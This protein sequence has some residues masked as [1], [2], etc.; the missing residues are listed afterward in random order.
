MT[1]GTQATQ[2]LRQSRRVSSQAVAEKHFDDFLPGLSADRREKANQSKDENGVSEELR[3][4][5]TDVFLPS[6]LDVIEILTICVD[7][8][9]ESV[10]RVVRSTV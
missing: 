8:Q 3:L 7:R 10:V 2:S 1:E 5:D 6:P 4:L 9:F